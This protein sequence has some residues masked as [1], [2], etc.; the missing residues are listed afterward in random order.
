MRT[1]IAAVAEG[2]VARMHFAFRHSCGPP[3][4]LFR[5]AARDSPCGVVRRL[6]SKAMSRSI[7]RPA[8]ASVVVIASARS[9]VRRLARVLLFAP[10][11]CGP[12]IAAAQT[13][14]AGKDLTLAAVAVTATRTAQPIAELL[15]DLTLIGP[16]EIARAGVQSLTELLQ[17]QPGVEVIRN[18]GPGGVSGVFLRGANSAQTLVLIDGVRVSSSSAGTTTLEAIP[19]DQIDR[20]EILRGPASS[21][22][23]ADAIGGVIQVFTRRGGSALAGNANAGF[24]TWGTS[25]AGGGLSG[26][27]GPI[28][29]AVQ[30][31]TRRSDGFNAIVDPANFSYND[32]RDGY[33]ADNVSASVSLPWAQDQELSAH[34][35]RNRLNAQFDGGPGFDDRTITTV[36]SWQADSRNRLAAFWMS[37]LSVAEGSD[38]SLSKSGFGDSTFRT[39]Q[40]QYT[41]QNEF[42]LPLGTLTAGY[43][44]R[45][46]RLA[47]DAGFAVN[48][49][50]TDAAFGVYQ[51]K[52]DA[53]AVQAN[54]R[55]DDSDQFGG[56][57]TG[58]IAY[59]YRFSPAFRVSAGYGTAF[60]VP[61]FNDL[62]YPGFSNPSL[63]PETAKNLEGGV[64]WN[65]SVAGATVEARAVAWRN[66]V[67]DLIVFECDANFNC[68]P[69][70][71]GRATLDGVTLAVDARADDG[72]SLSASLDLQSP[73]DDASGNVLPRRARRHGALAVARP[74]G[75]VRVGVEVVASA[76]RFDDAANSRRLAGYGIVNV[77]AEWRVDRSWTLTA[78]ADNL[79]DRNYQLASGYATGGATFFA[80]VRWAL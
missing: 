67:R 7:I 64:Y 49:R 3:G 59:G 45:E 54:L 43:E 63:M 68:A 21:L 18:G 57:T 58:A 20:I 17:R 70:N 39:R 69:Q 61:T 48:E 56:R 47:T 32:D 1:G 12:G 72:T 13:A 31:G 53:H 42:A 11:A 25:S 29:F 74:F 15:A 5:I 71:V 28:R 77:T 2:G 60:K 24:G 55:R 27:A 10:L 22:Y 50:D 4:A 51:L 9:A 37:R 44:R 65:G 40:R 33:R 41:W 30:A 35:F 66:R 73:K 76:Y 38:D 14:S 78:R 75:P 26:S 46:E 19:L 36:E 80:G 6:R 34:Y 8:T 62:Y 52:L 23:G 16:D 79:L